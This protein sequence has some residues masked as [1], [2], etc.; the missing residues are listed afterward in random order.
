MQPSAQREVRP[1]N[2]LYPVRSGEYCQVRSKS[3]ASPFLRSPLGLLLS[4]VHELETREL[5][6]IRDSSIS[7]CFLLRIFVERKGFNLFEHPLLWASGS[8]SSLSPH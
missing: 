1:H 3:P 2:Q 6:A 4:P 7:S 5:L 8:S